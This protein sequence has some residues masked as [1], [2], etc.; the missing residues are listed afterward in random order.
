MICTLCLDYRSDEGR[1]CVGQVVQIGKTFF[2]RL[3]QAGIFSCGMIGADNLWKA[4]NKSPYYI[5][6]LGSV[7]VESVTVQATLI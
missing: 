7:T 4:T 3:I 1:V 2:V 6:C 5:D